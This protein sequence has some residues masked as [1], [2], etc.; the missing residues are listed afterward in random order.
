METFMR[1]YVCRTMLEE[2]SSALSSKKINIP[3][4]LLIILCM[5]FYQ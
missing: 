3:V 1:G 4:K 5:Q 2:S